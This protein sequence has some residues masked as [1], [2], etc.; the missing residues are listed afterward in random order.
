MKK[1]ITLTLIAASAFFIFGCQESKEEQEKR[2]LAINYLRVVAKSHLENDKLKEAEESYLKLIDLVPDDASVYANL[3]LVYLKQSDY[4]SAQTQINKALK[5]AP[6]NPDIRMILAKYFELTRQSDQAIG[7]LEKIIE[8]HPDHTKALYNLAR[9]YEQSGGAAALANQEKYLQRSIEK[10][11]GNIIPRLDLIALLIKKGAYER[12]THQLEELPKIFSEFP[13]EAA[14]F[15]DK[16][17]TALH[18]ADT[19]TAASAAIIM[20]N[21]LKVT[22]QYQSDLRDLEG[23]EGDLAGLAMVSLG[24]FNM[25]YAQPGESILNRIR[26]LD[27]TSQINLN[28]SQVPV[29]AE[30]TSSHFALEDYND[31][32]YVDVYFSSFSASTS[33]SVTRLLRNNFGSMFQ[34]QAKEAGI[35]H[36]GRETAALFGD[37]DNDGYSDLYVVKDGPNILYK[38]NGNGVFSN[39]AATAKV[40]DPATGNKILYLDADLDGDL[41]LL[42]TRPTSNLLYRN[43]ADGT[44]SEMAAPMG[45]GLPVANCGDAAFA[46]FDEDGDLDLLL[47]NS[48]TS[49]LLFSNERHGKFSNFTAGSGLQNSKPAVAVAAADFNNDGFTDLLLLSKTP[50]TAELYTNQ[51][52]GTFKIK[53]APWLKAIRNLLPRDAAFFDFDNDGFLDLLIVGKPIDKGGK[54]VLLFHNDS[55]GNFNDVSDLL[56]SSV[57]A[58]HQIETADYDKDGDLDV[59]VA[60]LNGELH[61]LKNEGGNLNHFLN[62]QLVGLRNGNNKNNHFGIGAKVE[63]RSGELYQ[64]RVVTEPIVHFGLGSRLK[65]DVVRVIWTNGVA[66]NKFFPGTDQELLESQILKGSCAFLYTWDGEQYVFSKD[67]MWRS[68]LG[69][70]LGIM[71]ANTAYAPA[72]PSQEYLKIPGEQM[73]LQDGKYTVQITEELWETAYFDNLELVVLDHPT[74]EHVFVDERFTLPPYTDKYDVFAVRKKLSPVSAVDRAGT[75]LL[76]QILEK[77]DYYISN[78]QLGEYQGVTETRDLVLDPGKDLP[79][80]DVLLF[81]NGW[82]FPSDASINVALSQSSKLD[83]IPPQLQV[84][85]KNGAWVTVIPN[86]GFPMGKDKTMIVDLSGKFLSKD[87]RVRIRTNMEIYWDEIFFAPKAKPKEITATRLKPTSADLHYRGFS[88]IYRKGGQYG[89]HWFDYNEVEKGQKWRDLI[90]NYTRFGEVAPLLTEVDDKLVIM[91]SGDEMTVSFDAGKLPTLRSGWKRDFLIYSEGWIK[92]GDLNTAYGKTVDPLPFHGMTRYPY[93]KD[94]SFPSDAEHREYLKNYNTRKVNTQ[95]FRKA[96]MDFK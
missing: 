50:G 12:A 31:D 33:T 42:V 74:T 85:H 54:G 56:P 75:N 79:S 55:K 8:K 45:L 51:G 36:S 47:T 38:N 19:A 23:P 30:G 68:A 3:A 66:Q 64:M 72:A 9:M 11:P 60:D 7:E 89:P 48:D 93:G 29:Q 41:D 2:E 82:I 69:M 15:Y 25:M 10:S 62:I 20:Q 46:D 94:E 81:L 14:G 37:Y 87:R 73:K 40:D 90:G 63:I 39:V 43:N 76:P 59:F 86:M 44:F 78:F 24:D 53:S 22:M 34:E 80:G 67:M 92:D 28:D 61:L 96:V 17:M 21:L 1:I 4:K 52:D 58:G 70:P 77:D 88:Q 26:F 5:R 13:K 16:T 18:A 35:Q 49:N 95:E 71:G 6:D 27:V 57:A 32:G 91:N 65:A 83:V 84:L